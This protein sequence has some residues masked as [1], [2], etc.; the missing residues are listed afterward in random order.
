MIA[1]RLESFLERLYR[2]LGARH[3]AA[4]RWAALGFLMVAVGGLVPFY[5]PYIP[6]SDGMWLRPLLVFEVMIVVV[7]GLGAAPSWKRAAAPVEAW[8]EGDRSPE[9]SRA[10]WEC[11]RTLPSILVQR[12]LFW[13]V[14]GML[15]PGLIYAAFEFDATPFRLVLATIA[16]L[17]GGMWVAAVFVPAYELY[18]R[19][20]RLDIARHVQDPGA[21]SLEVRTSIGLKLLLAVPLISLLTG[22]AVAIAATLGSREWQDLAVLAFATIVVTFVISG[23]MILLLTRALEAPIGDLVDATT[24]V[25]AGD[26]SARAEVT[27][28]D[29]IGDIGLSFNSMLDHIAD[30]TRQNEQLLHEVRQSRARIIAASDAER[31][32][33]ERKIHDGTQQRLVT[34][35][36]KLRMLQESP[37]LDER[38]RPR[39]DACARE[40][41]GALDDLREL[42][43][44]LHPSVLSTDG[45]RPALQHLASRSSLPVTIDVPGDRWSIPVESTAYFVASE[46]LANVVKYANASAATVSLTE[47]G[48]H[49]VLVISDDGVGGATLG[50]GTGLAGLA[51]RLEAV[52]GVLTIDS[53]NGAGTVVRAVL[54]ARVEERSTT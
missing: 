21:G 8:L 29:E 36:L 39:V 30:Y 40:L 2:S 20:L 16:G 42:A 4:A 3:L 6:E 12:A 35:A 34:L 52:G 18:L 7:G 23:G 28:D 51:D 33:V 47:E 19:P 31:I 14:A 53:P 46:A 22:L 45:L 48:D 9:Q 10:A 49:L 11:V 37:S 17:A 38:L 27:S 54:P 13:G 25:L 24:R 5:M 43:R 44:G 1:D 15:V 32:R 26:L 41:D 50:T